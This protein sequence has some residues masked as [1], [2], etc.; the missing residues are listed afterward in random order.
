MVEEGDAHVVGAERKRRVKSV[1]N[2]YKNKTPIGVNAGCQPTVGT[3]F[4]PLVRLAD[5]LN[6][7]SLRDNAPRVTDERGNLRNTLYRKFRASRKRYQ[8]TKYVSHARN[9][10]PYGLFW[11]TV[12]DILGGKV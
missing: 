5:F 3:S 2:C 12:T 6:L 10:S 1:L 7:P 9:H 4:I 8:I 11:D